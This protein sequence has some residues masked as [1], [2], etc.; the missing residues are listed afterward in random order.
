M[1]WKE[2]RE[3]EKENWSWGYDVEVEKE[4]CAYGELKLPFSIKRKLKK[5]SFGSGFFLLCLD[6]ASQVLV[7]NW[8]P[9]VLQT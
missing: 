3:F 7:F 2:L 4:Q 6:K 5:Q 1:I 8:N 9:E